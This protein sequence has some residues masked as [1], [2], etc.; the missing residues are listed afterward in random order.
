MTFDELLSLVATEPS[1]TV[2]RDVRIFARELMAEA[3]ATA[4]MRL[5]ALFRDPRQ[6]IERHTFHEGHL[7]GPPASDAE[8]EQ[9]QR[10]WPRHRLPDD[11]VALLRRVNGIHLWADLDQGRSYQGRAPLAEWELARKR[12][13]GDHADPAD[14]A[15]RYVALSYHADGAAYAVL[16]AET[17]RYFLM[18]A[19]GAD[20]SC[21]IGASVPDL[22]AWLWSN[23]IEP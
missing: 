3:H 14:L 8:I 22:L 10:A 13:W 12:M 5:D 15:D 23:R 9:W 16:D 7:L 18:D 21:P 19:C 2:E 1:R 17:G 20:E 6:T 4:V 11:L